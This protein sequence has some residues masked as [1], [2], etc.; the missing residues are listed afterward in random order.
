MLTLLGLIGNIG[1]AVLAA[2]GDFLFAGILV[3]VASALDMFD[4]ALARATGQATPFGSAFDA[5]VDR[6][7]EAAVLFG[8]LWSSATGAG[9]RKSC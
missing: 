6:V 1:A 7:S 9:G 4:G 2:N 3:L 5:T 8:L